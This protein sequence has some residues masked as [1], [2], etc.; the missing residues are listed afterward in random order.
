MPDN[1]KRRNLHPQP[2]EKRRLLPYLSAELYR[3]LT[4]HC[5]ANGQTQS[6]VVEAA[7]NGQLAEAAKA[8]RWDIVANLLKELEARRR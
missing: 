6:A 7:L 2:G 5:A 8:G 4:S 1:S 3:R